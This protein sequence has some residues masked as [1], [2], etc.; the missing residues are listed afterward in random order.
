M[1]KEPLVEATVVSRSPMREI[2]DRIILFA[3]RQKQWEVVGDKVTIDTFFENRESNE[4]ESVKKLS[5][6]QI[7][8]M[9]IRQFRLFV[10]E[11]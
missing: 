9:I 11:V 4:H 8:C 10:V 3:E 2:T 7:A 5:F 6:C 1:Q